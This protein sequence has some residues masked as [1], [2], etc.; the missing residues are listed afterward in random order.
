MSFVYE[1]E[2]K[3]TKQ[4]TGGNRNTSSFLSCSNYTQQLSTETSSHT[5]MLQIKR[6]L[7][8][9]QKTQLAAHFNIS[10]VQACNCMSECRVNVMC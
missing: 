3:K 8:C 7:V 10:S 6:F 4:Q 5:A 9:V 1:N 2:K